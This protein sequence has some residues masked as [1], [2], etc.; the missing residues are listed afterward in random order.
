MATKAYRD[1]R[2]G[3]HATKMPPRRHLR[4]SRIGERGQ[5]AEGSVPQRERECR[6]SGGR[7]LNPAHMLHAARQAVVQGNE[8]GLVH[9][10]H[11]DVPGVIGADV[12]GHGENPLRIGAYGKNC[13][14]RLNRSSWAAPDPS[15]IGCSPSPPASEVERRAGH[16]ATTRAYGPSPAVLVTAATTADASGTTVTG[17]PLIGAPKSPR[18]RWYPRFAGAA[19][20]PLPTPLRCRAWPRG[21]PA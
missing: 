20:P 2:P 12:P 17:D 3:T 8:A 16:A 19:R 14:R 21:L 18:W 7:H 11:G 4:P 13:T 9:D 15:A 1:R 5:K 6:S 10:R